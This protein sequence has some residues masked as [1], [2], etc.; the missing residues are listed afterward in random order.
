MRT[1]KPRRGLAGNNAEKLRPDQPS[2]QDATSTTVHDR[3][4]PSRAE[5]DARCRPA[6]AVQTFAEAVP[7]RCSWRR[8]QEDQTRHGGNHDQD[9]KT[10]AQLRTNP[11]ASHTQ[12]WMRSTTRKAS[13]RDSSPQYAKG[14]ET[15]SGGAVHYVQHVDKQGMTR[16]KT[17][18]ANPTASK[19]AKLSNSEKHAKEEIW[20][21]AQA[22]LC[23]V[24]RMHLG[25]TPFVIQRKCVS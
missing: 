19:R 25:Q 7:A 2:S 12:T 23:V 14:V 24:P 11:T 16:R 20:R 15:R 1:R 18:R 3:R 8:A 6:F 5:T 4:K 17:K 21:S 22:K 10:V 9:K 13:A